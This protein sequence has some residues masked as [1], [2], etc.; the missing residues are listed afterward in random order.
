MID[1]GIDPRDAE[2]PKHKRS[3]PTRTPIADTVPDPLA[4]APATDK[5]HSVEHMVAEFVSK[6]L[7]KVRRRSEYAEQILERD[8]LPRWRGRDA[9]TIRPR[10]VIELLDTIVER[11]SPV[12]ANRTANVLAQLFKHGI[13]RGTVETSPVVLLYR[14]GGKE[15]PRDRALSEAELAAFLAQGDQVMRYQ[16]GGTGR[17]PRMAHVLRLLLATGVR[18]QELALAEWR[19]VTLTGKA[20]AWCIPAEHS[21]TGEPHT[22]PLSPFAVREFK[23]LKHYAKE[24]A[25]VLP[26][27]DGKAPAD[28]KLITRAVARNLDRFKSIGVEA[29]VPH[30]LRRTCRTGLARLRVRPEIAER[31]LNHKLPGMHAVNDQHDYLPEMRK[32]LNQWGAHLDSHDA[33]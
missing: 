1:R 18:R 33:S 32:A 17:T 19:N 4:A 30:D 24:S 11:G 31:V 21:K 14:P 8:V 10:E 3:R 5:P 7:R 12:M 13:H 29:F 23:A 15:P 9:R 22:V 28:P 16:T 27:D 6:H 2:R 25:Y 26:R 20:P